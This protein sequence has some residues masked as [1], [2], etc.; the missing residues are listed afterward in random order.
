MRGEKEN[1]EWESRPHER[2]SSSSRVKISKFTRDEGREKVNI[3]SHS[4]QQSHVKA[5]FIFYYG[6]LPASSP[7]YATQAT[8]M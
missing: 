3:F 5:I 4:P 7:N 2:Y 1:K 6:S 8:W